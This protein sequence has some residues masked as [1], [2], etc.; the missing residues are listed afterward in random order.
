MGANNHQ[1]FISC[2][3]GIEPILKEE[4]RGLGL[5]SNPDGEN[6][7][8]DY[9]GEEAGGV[10][11]EGRL[12][13][14]YKCNL[15]LRTASRVSVRLGEFYTAAFSELRKK[16]SRLSWEHFLVPGQAVRLSVTCHKS[17]LYHSDAVAERVLG[18]INDR[19]TAL[20]SKN[21]PCKLS[22]EGQ[23]IL[24]RLVNN[25][26]TVSVDS[27][28]NLLHKRGY[29]QETAKAPLRETLAAALLLAAGYDGSL[30]L[31]DPFCGSGTIPIEAALI[32]GH[33]PPG[34][35]RE[36]AFTHW[37][38]FDPAAWGALLQAA[39]KGITPPSQP[40]FGYDRDAGAVK[41]AASN[42][43]RAGQKDIAS[44]RQQPI[45][46]LQ[47]LNTP[48]WIVTNPPY[49]VRV[50]SNKDL[51]DLYA[52]FGSIILNS[53]NG[54]QVGVLCN[55]PVLAGNLGLPAPD[56]EWRFINGGIPVKFQIYKI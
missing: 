33:I 54:W 22:D 7:R 49:G 6:V 40:I 12:E 28:G 20:T 31:I 4:I 19:F 8:L 24:V 37:P 41:I 47:A 34:I 32:A 44:F 15:H 16:A 30:P 1:I 46:E 42:A 35:A 53:F 10:Q 39:R 55:D 18:A 36:F 14:V 11:L 52:R 23:L 26:C 56:S 13:D 29:R 45:S 27:S 50:N 51:R 9:S 25:Q 2:A 43:A 48:G 5:Y 17:K 21:S 38:N 3:P